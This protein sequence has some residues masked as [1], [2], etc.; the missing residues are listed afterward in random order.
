MA[1]SELR[2][3]VFLDFDVRGERFRLPGLI[4]KHARNIL[5]EYGCL[6]AARDVGKV[7]FNQLIAGSN[8]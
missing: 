5:G 3:Q 4:S 6:C 8:E 2:L 7:I 1:I